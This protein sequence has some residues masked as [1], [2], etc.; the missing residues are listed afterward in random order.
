MP[1]VLYLLGIIVVFY[2]FFSGFIKMIKEKAPFKKNIIEY[3]I[4]TLISCITGFLIISSCLGLFVEYKEYIEP[5][6][7]GEYKTV[8]GVVEII[9]KDEH[10]R[11][12]DFVVNNEY[13]EIH[14]NVV[15]NVG[16]KKTKY[17][18]DKQNVVIK[19]VTADDIIGGSDEKI[20]VIMEIEYK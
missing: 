1:T 12:V 9:E 19:Y 5:Y 18:L 15:L 10:N 6:K 16:I 20:N 13:F 14:P 4:V 3:S 11:Y 2:L 17:I 7:N 8:S